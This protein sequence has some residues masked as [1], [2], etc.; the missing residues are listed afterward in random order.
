MISPYDFS[1]VV[2]L[3]G[4]G[5]SAESGLKTFRDSGGLWEGHKVEDVATPDAFHSNPM[6]VHD[7]YNMRRQQLLNGAKPNT[8]HQALAKFENKFSGEF[9]LITQNVDNLHELGGSKNVLHMHG[10]LLKVRCQN[11]G[12][13]FDIS[14]NIDTDTPCLCCG[15]KGGMRPHIVWFGEIPLYMDKIEDIISNCDLFVSIGTSGQV[16]P[17]AG[18]VQLANLTGARSVEL[19]LEPSDGHSRFT[20]AYQGPATEIVTKFFQEKNN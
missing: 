6:L 1:S 4:A 12:T 16:Y 15:T 17:A 9:T 13:V 14:S 10:E 20:Y 11:S 7:F 19:N 5:I 2:I 18:F 3:T 8:A